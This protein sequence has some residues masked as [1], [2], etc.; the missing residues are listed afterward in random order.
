MAT[1]AVAREAV[2]ALRH[3][4]ARIEGRL[5]ERLAPPPNAATH[6]VLRAG[7]AVARGGLG[8]IATGAPGLDAALGGGLPEGALTEIHARE[9]RDVAA[10]TGLVLALAGIALGREGRARPPLAWIGL[11]DGFGEAG[12]PH[13]PGVAALFGIEPDRLLFCETARLADALWIAE[14][15]AR[16]DEPGAVVLELRGNPRKLDLTAT[17]RLHRRAMEA[18]RPFFLLRHSARPEPT[19]A[20][21]RLVVSSAPAGLRRTLSGPLPGSIGP[22]AFT[23]A[24]DKSRHARP[25][26]FELE[27]NLH[28]RTLWQRR[29]EISRALVP[30]SGHGED[31]APPPRPRLALRS[32]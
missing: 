30:L 2:A 21:V 29:P 11:T 27:W 15:A 24:I 32:G 20:P 22:P 18:G 13:A 31:L 23:V 8:A 19:A 25:G 14:E 16:L 28:D 5:P 7:G 1:T 10:A 3:Q 6:V 12:F 4:I 9:T 26:Q 17:R